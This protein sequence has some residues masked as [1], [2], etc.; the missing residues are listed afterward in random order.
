MDCVCEKM[1]SIKSEPVSSV[2][3]SR[4][5]DKRPVVNESGS[6]LA[7]SSSRRRQ[8]HTGKSSHKRSAE[9]SFVTVFF[10]TYVAGSCVAP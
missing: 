10:Y 4:R 3:K 5:V 6:S 8:H 2:S 7:V 1:L 9:V